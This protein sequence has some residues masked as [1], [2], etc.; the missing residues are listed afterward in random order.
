MS[1]IINEK[2]S[3]TDIGTADFSFNKVIDAYFELPT[4]SILRNIASVVPMKMST[5][6]VIN[7]RRNATTGSY[8]TVQSP[9]T[10]NDNSAIPISTGLS[11]EAIQD[12]KNQYDEDGYELAASLLKGIVDKQENDD[13]I[14]FLNTNSLSTPDL[15]LSNSINAE[16]ILFELTQR[17]QELVIKMN[18]PNYR[19]FD[20]FVILPFKTAASVTALN[21]YLGDLEESRQRLAVSKIGKTRY[22][23]NPDTSTTTAYVGLNES[24]KKYR[25]ASSIIMG[26]YQ[27]EILTS[28]GIEDFQ[29]RVGIINRYATTVNPLSDVGS[30]MLMHFDIKYLP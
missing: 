20:A 28:S 5:G 9:L 25:G 3:N 22:F 1:E 2:V 19:T 21:G 18:T 27:T 26:D 6:N 24:H 4:A 15:N 8:E 23:V 16:N 12:L 7:L 17:V 10:V 14:T 13:L 11:I 29:Q 30:E